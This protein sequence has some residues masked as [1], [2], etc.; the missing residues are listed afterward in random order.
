MSY[1][2]KN[3]DM[4]SPIPLTFTQPQI[5]QW[6][7]PPGSFRVVVNAII[8]VRKANPGITKQFNLSLDPEVVADELDSQHAAKLAAA[9]HTAY[10]KEGAASIPFPKTWSPQRLFQNA[11]A[12][13]EAVGKVMV[14]VGVYVDW[15]GSGGIPVERNHAEARAKVC[16][17]CDHNKLKGSLTDYFTEP[18]AAAMN[19]IL[20]IKNDMK[21][22][23]TFEDS[24]HVC[25]LCFCPL[26]S[27]V[28]TPISH[29]KA[30]LNDKT[31]SSLP[32]FCWIKQESK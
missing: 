21:L 24:L 32:D 11:K 9:G 4:D 16:S 22:M 2:L 3:R 19:K 31:L 26:K 13:A 23:T 20:A 7:P 27:K 6:K 30:K 10:L 12:A 1:R 8:S 25:D 17:T 18:A 14:G 5:P 29:I 15:L 28:W